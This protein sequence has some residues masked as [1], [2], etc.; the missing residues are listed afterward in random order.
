MSRQLSVGIT[1]RDR[2]AAL[3]ACL[4]SLAA[5][6]HLD[7][8]VLLFDDG[9]TV[10]AA[11]QIHASPL[12]VRVIR[13]ASTPGYIVGRNRLV[14]EAGGVFVLLLD[15]DTRLLSA[16]G[17]ESAIGVLRADPHVAA[18]AFA[19]AE[20]DGRPWPAA[21]Q[22]SRAQVPTVVPSFIGFAHLLRRSVF[23]ELSGYRES[24]EFYG[25]EKDY[26]LRLLDAGHQTVYLPGALIAHVPDPATRDRRRYLRFVARNDCLGTLYNDP[27]TRLL[28][29]L[30]ARFALYF[31]MRRGWKI[32]D[33]WGGL[34]L[35]RDVMRRIPA[36]W[37]E[38]R[39]VSRGTL[40]RWR[41]LRRHHT[42]YQV[43]DS[44]AG[45]AGGC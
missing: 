14:A 40:A 29:M 23:L 42:S 20:A 10:P 45:G 43:P 24:F 25:E 6:R 9:S 31:R 28:W 22:P 36:V 35:A 2:P 13:D 27:M 33:P 17:V 26:C 39:P 1:T 32:R 11:E 19:Q 34:W 5:I 4:A 30:P 38:R 16:G 3:R 41:E 12:P 21:M 8:E 18:V 7:P 44:Q 37:K 15:D